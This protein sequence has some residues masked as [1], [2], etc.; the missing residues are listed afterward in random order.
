MADW[1]G[2]VSSVRPRRP[3]SRQVSRGSGCLAAS[4]PCSSMFMLAIRSIV[5]S[6]SKPWNMLLWKCSLLGVL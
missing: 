6:K 5:L 3:R 1:P 4:M 2:S